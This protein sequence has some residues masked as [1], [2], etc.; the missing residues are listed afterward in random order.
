MPNPEYPV[1]PS[2]LEMPMSWSKKNEHIA[3]FREVL[4]SRFPGAALDLGLSETR[5]RERFPLVDEMNREEL[6]RVVLANMNQMPANEHLSE[7]GRSYSPEK[8]REEVANDRRGGQELIEGYRRIFNQ[9]QE[10][11]RTRRLKLVAEPDPD[12]QIEL[13]DFPY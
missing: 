7:G 13:P 3:T 11:A 12:A 2:N 10:A 1:S 8:L 6:K 4:T 9:L 5:Q